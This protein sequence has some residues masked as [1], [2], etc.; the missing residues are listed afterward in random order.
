VCT[1]SQLG[2]LNLL[3]L[4]ILP[5]PLTAKQQLVIIPDHS[6][7]GMVGCGE[8]HFEKNESFKKIT[9]HFLTL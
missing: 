8:K 9:D 4:L 6:E 2:W 3:Q 5:L 1:K 7:E